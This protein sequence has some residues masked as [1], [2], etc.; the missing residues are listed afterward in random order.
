M[1]AHV[2]Y[3]GFKSVDGT[4]EYALRVRVPGNQDRDFTLVIANEAFL[5][6]RVRYQDAP[7][8]CFLKLQ[9]ELLACPEGTHPARK[10]KVTDAELEEYRVAHSPKQRMPRLKPRGPA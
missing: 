1:S 6:N 3:L 5:A 2:E 4:R 8:I 9:R 7:E 10:L